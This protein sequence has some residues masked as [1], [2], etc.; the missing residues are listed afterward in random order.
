MSTPRK[1]IRSANGD[2]GRIGRH[3]INRDRRTNLILITAAEMFREQG[4]DDTRI[5]DIARRASVSP[6]TVYAYF[7][8][9]E[10]ILVSMVTLHRARNVQRRLDIVENPPDDVTRAMVMFEHALLTDAT[11]YLDIDLWGRIAA[12]GITA[13]QSKVGEQAINVDRSADQYRRQILDTLRGRGKLTERFPL[14]PVAELLRAASFHVWIR[15]LRRELRT[16][17][18]AKKVIGTHVAFILKDVPR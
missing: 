11:R 15:F 13:A 5:E 7:E 8:T 6:G 4:Y 10:N 1:K 2:S 16:L 14:E 18:A 17:A 3:Q 9:K 12:A